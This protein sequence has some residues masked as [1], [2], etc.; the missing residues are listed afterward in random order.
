MPR[1]RVRE[2]WRTRPQRGLAST[3]KPVQMQEPSFELVKTACSLSISEFAYLVAAGVGATRRGSTW[4]LDRRHGPPRDRLPMSFFTRVVAAPT[5]LG[6]MAAPLHVDASRIDAPQMPQ[7][8]PNAHVALV[9]IEPSQTPV[10]PHEVRQ[11]PSAHPCTHDIEA[12]RLYWSLVSTDSCEVLH[13][14]ALLTMRALVQSRR[15][16]IYDDAHPDR[17]PIV[18]FGMVNA[19]RVSAFTRHVLVPIAGCTVQ[20]HIASSSGHSK[21]GEQHGVQR[22]YARRT[23]R[24]R[25]R[26]AQAPRVANHGGVLHQLIWVRTASNREIVLDFTGPQFGIDDRLASTGTP[27]WREELPPWHERDPSWNGATQLRGF[28]VMSQVA[29]FSSPQLPEG[30]LDDGMHAYVGDWIRDSALGVL[31]HRVSQQQ[32]C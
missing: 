30:L 18:E 3:V 14:G 31:D 12:E 9:F 19:L 25:V 8:A 6:G 5:Q 26:F 28:E 10:L 29:S 20:D 15:I 11:A 23:E 32:A 24:L 13:T 2:P 22:H 17:S 16:T 7:F 4:S 27:F 1:T 21:A